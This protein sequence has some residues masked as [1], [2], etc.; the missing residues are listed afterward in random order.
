MEQLTELARRAMAAA[1]A[2]YS[3]FRVGAAIET[4]SGQV[5]AGCNVENASLGLTI[6]AER[7]AAVMAVANGGRRFR[8]GVVVTEGTRAVAPCGA[9]RQVLAEFGG[10]GMEI[11]GVTE[12]ETKRWLLGDLLPAAFREDTLRQDDGV[13]QN[14]G[15]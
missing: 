2:P 6:C 12:H 8:R 5:F 7:S 15:E 11:C 3:R 9:C 10:D 4:H 1:Y 13:R 14:D